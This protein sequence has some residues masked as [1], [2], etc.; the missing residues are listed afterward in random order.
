MTVVKMQDKKFKNI[1]KERLYSR[2]TNHL[3][4]PTTLLT[5]QCIP[6]CPIG[7]LLRRC[8]SDCSRVT[9]R[10]C[11]DSRVA[12]SPVIGRCPQAP[13]KEPIRL[14]AATLDIHPKRLVNPKRGGM[15]S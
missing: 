4:P 7:D 10:D 14:Q 6:P 15:E 13:A 12:K 5:T 1:L 8:L 9:L 11:D 2:Q 3:R